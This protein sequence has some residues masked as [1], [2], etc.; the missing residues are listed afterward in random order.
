SSG[1]S[2]RIRS[3]AGHRI[4]NPLRI[5]HIGDSQNEEVA[6]EILGLTKLNWNTTAFSTAVPITIKFAEGVGRILSELAEDKALQDHYRF[7]M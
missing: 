5:T 6:K 4:P 2:P 7:F 3:Y 1:Y